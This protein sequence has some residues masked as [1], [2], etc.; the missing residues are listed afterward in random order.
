M[1]CSDRDEDLSSTTSAYYVQIVEQKVEA[2]NLTR[3][4][5]VE[6]EYCSCIVLSGRLERLAIP[7]I[8]N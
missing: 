7:T 2:A 5:R 4:G 6:F 1:D 8:R 3:G